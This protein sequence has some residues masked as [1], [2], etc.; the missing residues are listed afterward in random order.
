MASAKSANRLASPEGLLVLS[1]RSEHV[2][3]IFAGQKKVELRKA[4]PVASFSQVLIYE[5]GGRGLVGRFTAVAVHE[6]APDEL[7]RKFGE[8]AASKHRF[9]TYFAGR[10]HGY[11][12]EIADPI[13]FDKP[14]S[15][16]SL[17]E[18]IPGFQPPRSA[19][20]I[21]AGTPAFTALQKLVASAARRI[22][23]LRPIEPRD[24]ALFVD[25]VTKYVGRAYADIGEP[26]ARRILEVS[27]LGYDPDGFLT[28][29]KHVFSIYSTAGEHIGF[30]TL[31]RKFGGAA[32]TGPTVLLGPYRHKGYGQATRRAI[33]AHARANSIRKLYCT[34][35]ESETDI[36]NYLLRA[37]YR[38]EAHLQAHYDVGHG[39]LGFGKELDVT[40]EVR[41][42]AKALP[43][44]RGNLANASAWEQ[45][46]LVA[47][48]E[49]LFTD[50]WF[51]ITAVVARSVVE[52]ALSDAAI[53]GYEE[54]PRRLV[55][56]RDG[57]DCVGCVVLVPKRGGSCKGVILLGTSHGRTVVKLLEA[58]EAVTRQWRRRKLYYLHP[59]GDYATVDA[60]R[61][62][63]FVTE[64]VLRSPYRQGQD[65]I[66]LSKFLAKQSR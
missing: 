60:L 31:T 16:R 11:A 56:V 40:N 64:G 1:I 46:D 30:T 53:Q 34:A 13:E 65:V 20:L 44:R 2:A 42:A 25:L 48:V 41:L 29:S 55:C 4:L 19:F 37:G 36:V 22:V 33:E 9:D 18:H 57:D 45:A 62:M 23:T 5:S 47:Q 61:E 28:I 3:R 10:T 8:V 63:A 54:K 26:F 15:K 27:D 14:I 50:S 24:R 51:P 39:E 35:P 66:V 49:R 32:K 6:G 7:W 58:A 59:I 21:P 52:A 38:V 17:A 43:V 12:I